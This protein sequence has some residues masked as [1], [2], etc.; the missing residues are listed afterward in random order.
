M[1]SF[2]PLQTIV[3]EDER[4]VGVGD[5]RDDVV[6][7]S[8]GVHGLAHPLCQPKVFIKADRLVKNFLRKNVQSFEWL[9]Q[10]TQVQ[11][12]LQQSAVDFDQ[13]N[14]VIA[15]WNHRELP[16]GP[17]SWQLITKPEVHVIVNVELVDGISFERRG[18]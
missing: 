3:P 13:Q 8:N 10:L 12:L 15:Q 17:L 1:S 5:P 7:E 4:R 11:L 6:I 18:R 9:Q 2:V 16:G 14:V